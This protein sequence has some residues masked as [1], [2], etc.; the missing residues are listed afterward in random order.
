MVRRLR[1]GV[2]G[3]AVSLGVRRGQARR[4]GASADSRVVHRAPD[5][6]AAADDLGVEGRCPPGHGR[7]L[8]R[9]HGARRRPPVRRVGAHHDRGARARPSV[10]DEAARGRSARRPRPGGGVGPRRGRAPRDRVGSYPVVPCLR[11]AGGES[12]RLGA[13]GRWASAA[14]GFRAASAPAG[15]TALLVDD[16]VTTGASLARSC[17]TLERAGVAVAA[18]ITLAA[19]P[20]P[21]GPGTSVP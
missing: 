4:P 6:P 19:T 15:E 21:G 9:R 18:A 14:A 13:R 1:G 12:R 3:A 11:N 16:V 2:V 10:F 17:S 20:R 8:R 5:R 7:L